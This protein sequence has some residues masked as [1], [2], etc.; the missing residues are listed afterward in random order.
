M[1]EDN[2]IGAWVERE[3]YVPSNVAR[4][5]NGSYGGTWGPGL[6]FPHPHLVGAYLPLREVR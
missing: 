5:R 3:A 4:P 6:D 2:V 1:V